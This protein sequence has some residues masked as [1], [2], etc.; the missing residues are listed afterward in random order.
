[1]NEKRRDSG[2][3]E[4]SYVNHAIRQN[5]VYE[6]KYL[7]TVPTFDRNRNLHI[8]N[9]EFN[10]WDVRVDLRGKFSRSKVESFY[11]DPQNRDQN[12]KSVDHRIMR[13]GL[14]RY[15]APLSY[16]KLEKLS[17]LS[18]K[19]P[20]IDNI[21]LYA[22]SKTLTQVMTQA[23]K[24]QKLMNKANM[25]MQ[26]TKKASKI[27]KLRNQEL[28]F[29]LMKPSL[30]PEDVQKQRRERP[31][32]RVKFRPITMKGEAGDHE[33]NMRRIQLRKIGMV[34]KLKKDFIRE[35]HGQFI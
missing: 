17:E 12:N 13:T 14:K 19:C 21:E 16:K 27:Y 29:P 2:G 1:M 32:N 10:I 26:N 15:R 11:R 33:I 22:R 31:A 24:D 25:E 30:T 23:E 8:V 3:K 6:K 20:Q 34:E 9:D 5:E 35:M 18:Q 28:P 7:Q 4:T